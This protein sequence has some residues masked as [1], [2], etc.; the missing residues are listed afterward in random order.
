VTVIRA[1]TGG[2]TVTCHID[3]DDT[4]RDLPCDLDIYPWPFDDSSCGRVVM[5]RT[6]DRV[7]DAV[8]AMEE[9]WR[10]ARPGAIVEI[11]ADHFSRAYA[12][13]DPA[14]K[15][16]V[17]YRTINFFSEN[18]EFGYKYYA[19]ARFALV[20]RHI[21]FG[22]GAARRPIEAL[23]NRATR[24]YEHFFALMVPAETL[25]FTLRAVKSTEAA[26]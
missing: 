15:R 22:P 11:T 16:F 7:D 10:I 17:S 23:A 14:R 26:A 8:R 18:V 20:D 25:R 24:V 13:T 4:A 12:R 19:T 2:L 6:L 21:V 9:V 5:D 1:G 3:D